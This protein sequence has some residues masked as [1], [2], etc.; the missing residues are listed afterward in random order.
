[1]IAPRVIAR[2]HRGEES[3]N[4]CQFCS[5]VR[6]V[7]TKLSIS[8]SSER[9]KAETLLRPNGL[10]RVLKIVISLPLKQFWQTSGCER[11]P[12][13]ILRVIEG[14]SPGKVSGLA[15]EVRSWVSADFVSARNRDYTSPKELSAFAPNGAS[16]D[17]RFHSQICN[18]G[19][20][21]KR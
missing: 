5:R 16:A 1:M 12:G 10:R 8:R 6:R 4:T 21:G 17:A 15:L 20:I 19:G 18:L 2:L 3:P 7:N 11:Q 9:A 13:V 14:P